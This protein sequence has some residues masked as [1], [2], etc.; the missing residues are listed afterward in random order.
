LQVE[1]KERAETEEGTK[2][3]GGLTFLFGADQ[4][5]AGNRGPEQGGKKDGDEGVLQTKESADHGRE[6]DIAEAHDFAVVDKSPKD[7]HEEDQAAAQHD[8]GEGRQDRTFG[9]VQG[10]AEC[11]TGQDKYFRN[12]QVNKVDNRTDDQY[13]AEDKI[14]AEPKAEPK[15]EPEA[16]GESRGDDLDQRVLDGDRRLAAR[17]A[18][19]QQEI[20]DNGNI[21]KCGNRF[22]TRRTKGTGPDDRQVLGQAVDQH[23]K[24]T[25]QT[26]AGQRDKDVNQ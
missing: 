7:A 25:P 4:I 22:S 20:T 21:L 3:Y 24:E 19:A 1:G 18:A 9:N 8:T 10:D 11:D 16:Q 2:R 5:D 6:F 23:V 15:P 12:E 14:E 13:A 17:T 26:G